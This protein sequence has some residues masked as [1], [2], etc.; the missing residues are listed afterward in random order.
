[1][2]AVAASAGFAIWVGRFLRF[3]SWDA[4]LQPWRTLATIGAHAADRPAQAV[5]VT[6]LFGGLLLVAHAA[7]LRDGGDRV[8]GRI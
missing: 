1:V 3:N 8:G 6:I 2:L 5:G 7:A 4:L